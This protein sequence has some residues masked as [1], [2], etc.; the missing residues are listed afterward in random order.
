MEKK[1][2]LTLLSDKP[3]APKTKSGSKFGYKDVSSTVIDIIDASPRPFTI[4][5]FGKWGRGKSTVLEEV[6]IRIDKRKYTFVKFDVWK[7]EGD[8]LRRSFLVDVASQI[9]ESLNLWD[10]AK[11]KKIS[12]KQ[13]ERKLYSSESAPKT[14]FKPNFKGLIVSGVA[15][16]IIYLLTRKLEASE[17]LSLTIASLPFLVELIKSIDPTQV[18]QKIS[19]ARSPAGSPE[20]FERIFKED[21]LDAARGTLVIA[22]DNLD[23]T[24]SGK[25]AELLS[26]IKTFLNSDDADDNVIF[27]IA[28]DNLAIKQHISQKYQNKGGDNF[29]A[30]EFLQKF[31]NVSID[32]PE[33]IPNEVSEYTAGLLDATSLDLE[34]RDDVLYLI[35]LFFNKNP[36]EIKQFINNLV[37]YYIQI[38]NAHE[39]YGFDEAFLKHN[40]PFI[41]FLLIMR[42]KYLDAYTSLKRDVMNGEG[43]QD[44]KANKLKN[45]LPEKADGFS[46][47]LD[48]ISKT[49]HV[50]PS[51]KNIVAFFSLRTSD[52]EKM[53]PGWDIFASNLETGEVDSSVKQ[54]EEFEVNAL[55]QMLISTLNGALSNT[56]RFTILSRTILE[57]ISKSNRLQNDES[58]SSTIVE[59]IIGN[60]GEAEIEKVFTGQTLELVL[61][62]LNNV[63]DAVRRDFIGQIATYLRNQ[64]GSLSKGELKSESLL[65]ESYAGPILRY[66]SGNTRST[67][68]WKPMLQKL[69]EITSDLVILSQV[70]EDQNLKN[71]VTDTAYTNFFESIDD[72]NIDMAT[73]NLEIETLGM[74]TGKQKMPD[75]LL[76][77]SA[78]L[79]NIPDLED[80]RNILETVSSK[81]I[82]F[83]ETADEPAQ[84]TV[85]KLTR[86]LLDLRANTDG[87]KTESLT[88]LLKGITVISS[89]ST[90][91]LTGE[92]DTVITNFIKQADVNSITDLF[93]V[94]DITDRATDFDNAIAERILED[95]AA[96]YPA[97]SNL[98]TDDKRTEIMV[99]IAGMLGDIPGQIEQLLHLLSQNESIIADYD[100]LIIDSLVEAYRNGRDRNEIKRI[101]HHNA[102]TNLKS[103]LKKPLR[104]KLKEI[105]DYERDQ[106]QSE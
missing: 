93:S 49:R 19:L 58:L 30:D 72:A 104:E 37:A 97:I 42:E 67:T 88:K 84:T 90:N 1:K 57:I 38:E 56:T 9:N 35:S 36:R 89:S 25:T 101:S 51:T 17:S 5:L 68:S 70:S 100:S 40:A 54:A 13:I 45:Y 6:R 82:E 62:N 16:V 96:L 8:S 60:T 94:L 27:L 11:G 59:I 63:K 12:S 74:L 83:P 80:R 2:R 92:T 4:G 7:Y 46:E 64:L 106:Q 91:S 39:T 81:L 75:L 23:R 52:T 78:L 18:L 44:I 20:Q 22:V 53:L 99:K 14:T 71:I 33:L 79:A 26:T 34:Q 95:P 103:S 55:K 73:I 21:I 24:Q 3:T 47:Y 98:V 15:F 61:T 69:L 50:N 32:M 10:K 66:Y 65:V 76:K 29:S 48:F 41:V 85:D 87:S 105:D 28:A 86:N 43:W 77:V 102:R 31:F